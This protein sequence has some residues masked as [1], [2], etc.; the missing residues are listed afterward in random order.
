[1]ASQQNPVIMTKWEGPTAHS[2]KPQYCK[3]DAVMGTGQKRHRGPSSVIQEIQLGVTGP[4]RTS[5]NSEQKK[6]VGTLFSRIQ[7]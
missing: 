7:M 6:M 4:Q 1:M 2:E 5:G 3:G